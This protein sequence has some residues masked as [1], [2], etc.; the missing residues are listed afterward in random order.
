MSISD[1]SEDVPASHA[2]LMTIQEVEK[3][4]SGSDIKLSLTVCNKRSTPQ[5]L[6]LQINAQTMRYTGIPTGH[7]YKEQ[8]EVRLQPNGGMAGTLYI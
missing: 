8:N 1:D 6:S 7:I 3:P 2:V 4:V 5:T